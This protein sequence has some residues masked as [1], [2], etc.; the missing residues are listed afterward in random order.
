MQKICELCEQPFEASHRARR[1]CS[2]SCS[3]IARPRGQAVQQYPEGTFYKRHAERLREDKK[4]KLA[5][6][7]LHRLKVRARRIA[8]EL[9]PI[10]QPCEECSNE[11]T[12]RHHDDYNKPE[13]IRWLCNR[14]HAEWHVANDG[15]WGKG[16]DTIGTRVKKLRNSKGHGIAWL[17]QQLVVPQNRLEDLEDKGQEDMDLIWMIQQFYQVPIERIVGD[18]G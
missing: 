4:T 16:K 10:Q 15:V 18:H 9:H 6:D 12:S 17:A 1:F 7:P 5:T 14:C 11:K 8:R 2:N 3:N 13:E